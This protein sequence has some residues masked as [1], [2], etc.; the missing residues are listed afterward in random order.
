MSPDLVSEAVEAYAEAHTSP[1]AEHLQAL[2]AETRATL[3]SSG[4]RPGCGR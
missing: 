3:E 1:A 4:H 2:A